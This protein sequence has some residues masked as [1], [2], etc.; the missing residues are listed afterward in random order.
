MIYS[1]VDRW[2]GLFAHERYHGKVI[3]TAQESKTDN[4]DRDRKWA[5]TC[6]AL[7]CKTFDIHDSCLSGSLPIY[8]FTYIWRVSHTF[9]VFWS[10]ACD[11]VNLGK[12]RS[13]E[14][15]LIILPC[16]FLLAEKTH[17][18][19]LIDLCASIFSEVMRRLD[20]LKSGGEY[21]VDDQEY[22]SSWTEIQQELVTPLDDTERAASKGLPFLGHRIRAL[23]VCSPALFS[24]NLTILFFY[25][26]ETGSGRSAKSEH[27]DMQEDPKSFGRRRKIMGDLALAIGAVDDAELYYAASVDL[28]RADGDR[29]WLAAALE[30]RRDSL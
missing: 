19:V 15:I 2:E 8:R 29:V 12:N 11:V 16:T 24:S 10:I 3:L 4:A 6:R 20:L 28:A 1:L 9:D 17:M 26:R 23:D 13:I 21:L 22:Q 30:V 7:A 5:K 27:S 14:L 18:D 25:Q